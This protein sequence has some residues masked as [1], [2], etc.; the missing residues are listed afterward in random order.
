[1]RQG[2]GPWEWNVTIENAQKIDIQWERVVRT[3]RSWQIMV[4]SATDESHIKLT[5]CAEGIE[6]I[7]QLVIYD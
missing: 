6:G 3:K 1:M 2:K 5:Q 4:S 7:T